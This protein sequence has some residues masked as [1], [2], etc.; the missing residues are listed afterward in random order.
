MNGHGGKRTGA[1]RPGAAI[2]ERRVMVLLGQGVSVPQIAE[3]FG[4]SLH[5]IKG[6]V[7]KLRNADKRQKG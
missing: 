4:V 2:D 7:I 6:R 3:R 5:V 1:G